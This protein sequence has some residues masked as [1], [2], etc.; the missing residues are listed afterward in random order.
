MTFTF[1]FILKTW[2]ECY[3]TELHQLTFVIR[4]WC[5]VDIWN[6]WK[7]LVNEIYLTFERDRQT[8]RQTDRQTDRDRQRQTE[9]QRGHRE[10]QRET[11]TDRQTDRQTDRDREERLIVWL[12]YAQHFIDHL[13]FIIFDISYFHKRIVGKVMLTSSRATSDRKDAPRMPS[14][15]T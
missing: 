13:L 2:I 4:R 6:W 9:R 15:K 5:D 12:C 14:N 7:I 11:E 10:R 1:L 8:N 3:F